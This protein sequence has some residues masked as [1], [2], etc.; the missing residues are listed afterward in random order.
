MKN[1]IIVALAIVY[2]LA[3]ACGNEQAESAP[4][5]TPSDEVVAYVDWALDNSPDPVRLCYIVEHQPETLHEIFMVEL[6]SV[7]ITELGAQTEDDAM[8][9]AKALHRQFEERCG[10]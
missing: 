10:S 8:A 9:L 7:A 1:R 4:E 5:P 2:V 6:A 3:V